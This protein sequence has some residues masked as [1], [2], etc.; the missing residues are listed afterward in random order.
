M[1][2]CRS[3]TDAMVVRFGN[4]VARTRKHFLQLRAAFSVTTDID[5]IIGARSLED[6]ICDLEKILPRD[7]QMLL[8]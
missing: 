2:A 5:L 4:R 6:K 7:C 8:Y 3:L 1:V